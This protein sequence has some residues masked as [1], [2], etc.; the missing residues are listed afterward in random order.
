[1][2]FTDPGGTR[3]PGRSLNTM[4]Y[5]LARILSASALGILVT[6]CATV[7]GDPY[8]EPSRYQVY[9]QPGYIYSAPPPVYQAPPVYRAPGVIYSAPP[10]PPST[11][12]GATGTTTAGT[13]AVTATTGAKGSATVTVPNATVLPVSGISGNNRPAK[14][15]AV[16][17]NA[18]RPAANRPSATAAPQKTDAT[19]TLARWHPAATP[20]IRRT[21]ARASSPTARN[22]PEP[23]RLVTTAEPHLGAVT[24]S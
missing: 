19:A 14:P 9:E 21:G 8:Y 24:K 17:A 5:T 15:T 13:R 6:G 3:T 12:V 4:T 11:T 2:G 20:P 16:P 22:S 23:P 1:M 10:P 18:T 7:P